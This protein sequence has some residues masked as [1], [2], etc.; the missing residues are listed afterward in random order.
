[1]LGRLYRHVRS[2]RSLPHRFPH[3]IPCEALE[4]YSKGFLEGH[5]CLQ[6]NKVRHSRDRGKAGLERTRN[7]KVPHGICS[8]GVF[9]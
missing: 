8:F 9:L 7:L 4:H 1:M 6:P 3:G 5:G 2:I